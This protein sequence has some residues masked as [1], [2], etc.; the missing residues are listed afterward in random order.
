MGR[1]FGEEVRGANHQVGLETHLEERGNAKLTTDQVDTH[2]SL[3]SFGGARRTIT[4]WPVR[5]NRVAIRPQTVPGPRS[6]LRFPIPNQIF[7]MVCVP[8]RREQRVGT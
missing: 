7:P 8:G 3:E 4:L 2:M 5:M 1:V 6:P